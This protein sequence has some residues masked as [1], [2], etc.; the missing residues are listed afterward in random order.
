MCFASE[1][2]YHNLYRMSMLVV[3]PDARIHVFRCCG[4]GL[5]SG[6]AAELAARTGLTARPTRGDTRRAEAEQPRAGKNPALA[7]GLELVSGLEPLTY[8]LR[9]RCSTS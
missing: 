6:A 9:M 3:R 5:V 8:A 4:A 1:V 7:V 2:L